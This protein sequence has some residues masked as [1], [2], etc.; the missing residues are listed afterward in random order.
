MQNR[1]FHLN[2]YLSL[3]AIVGLLASSLL[4]YVTSSPGLRFEH[5]YIYFSLFG[6]FCFSLAQG[7]RWVFPNSLCKVFLLY[8]FLFLFILVR[9][10]ISNKLSFGFFSSAENLFQPLAIIFL[11]GFWLGN[12]DADEIDTIFSK[13]IKVIFFLSC[14]NTCF[15]LCQIYFDMWWLTKYFVGEQ[16]STL[17]ESRTW[18][19]GGGKGR[20]LGVFSQPF[21][22]GL[23]YSL[24]FCLWVYF[25]AMIRSKNA[26]WV[27]VG[28]FVFL[29]GW[30]SGSKVFLFVG[31]A[32]GIGLWLFLSKKSLWQTLCFVVSIVLFNLLMAIYTKFGAFASLLKGGYIYNEPLLKV[33]SGGRF[34]RDD[35]SKLEAGF[36]SVW[37][38]N[39]LLGNGF[40]ANYALDSAYLQIFSYGGFIGCFLYFMI[41]CISFYFCIKGGKHNKKMRALLF[42][43]VVLILLAGFGA[44]VLTINRVS[45][46]L[47]VI[48][49]VLIFSIEKTN[50]ANSSQQI[51]CRV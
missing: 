26:A 7:V 49:C 44:P 43:I 16:Y 31:V 38:N 51:K 10:F 19:R 36:I 1:E 39:P 21:E 15:I 25:G 33:I 50:D 45:I 30:L 27:L 24:S 42:S 48:V 12:N 23:F 17:E 34:G 29:G 22:S 41:I 20:F 2:K 37:E 3:L 13:L 9:S 35:T 46:Y 8:F 6:I 14:L 28:L 18:Y 40:P 32:V 47:W 11:I 4:P 5:I